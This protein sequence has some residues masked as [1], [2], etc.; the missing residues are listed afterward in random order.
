MATNE[1]NTDGISTS[2]LSQSAGD[3]DVVVDVRRLVDTQPPL[4][5]IPEEKTTLN[6]RSLFKTN[7]HTSREFEQTQDISENRITVEQKTNNSDNRDSG[8]T[9]SKSND[10]KDIVLDTERQNPATSQSELFSINREQT[11][12]AQQTPDTPE[13][14]IT[15]EKSRS[16]MYPDIK[17]NRSINDR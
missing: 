11:K 5:P 9:V 7:S 3:A 15:K 17:T 14:R 1:D 4:N 16:N 8:S 10:N 13:I 2:Q 12:P 6:I